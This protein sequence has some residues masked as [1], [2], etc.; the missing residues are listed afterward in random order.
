MFTSISNFI[1]STKP[2]KTNVHINSPYKSRDKSK[3][4][5]KLNVIES[6]II[7]NNNNNK[8]LSNK[9]SRS[10]RKYIDRLF[11]RKDIEFESGFGEYNYN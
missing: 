3:R 1:I 6:P 11:R 9:K 8:S 10:V 7:N 4:I 2:R 5:E